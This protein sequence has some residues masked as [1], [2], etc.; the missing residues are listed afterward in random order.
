MT[1]QNDKMVLKV[2][3]MECK[4]FRIYVYILSHT[5]TSTYEKKGARYFST[6]TI[7]P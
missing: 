3:R 4:T 2:L 5:L 1:Q 7:F 6:S